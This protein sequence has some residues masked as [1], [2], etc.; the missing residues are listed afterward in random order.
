MTIAASNGSDESPTTNTA[1]DN[2]GSIITTYCFKNAGLE[3]ILGLEKRREDVGGWIRV[4]VV[5]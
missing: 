5:W 2:T 3:V 1:K 4:D